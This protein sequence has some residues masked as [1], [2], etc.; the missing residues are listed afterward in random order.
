MAK[1]SL[2]YIKLLSKVYLKTVFPYKVIKAFIITL[3]ENPDP[4]FL[5]PSIT[6]LLDLG[7]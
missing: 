4:I 3:R 1:R 5:L 2:S 7:I 6:L